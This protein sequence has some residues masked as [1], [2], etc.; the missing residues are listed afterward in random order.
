MVVEEFDPTGGITGA[1]PNDLYMATTDGSVW[2]LATVD[3]QNV[4]TWVQIGELMGPPGPTES[5][6]GSSAPTR[7]RPGRSAR[8]GPKGRLAR[9]A[10]PVRPALMAPTA[11][12]GP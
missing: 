12:R 11:G 2:E 9:R 1:Q 8:Q 7:P 10:T 5:R 3:G 4:Q 6:R